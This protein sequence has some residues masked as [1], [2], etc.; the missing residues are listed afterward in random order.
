[1]ESE[2]YFELIGL[3]TGN[4]RVFLRFR[5]GTLEDITGRFNFEFR[6][7]VLGRGYRFESDLHNASLANSGR[8]ENF[9]G[10][11][12]DPDGVGRIYKSSNG[13]QIVECERPEEYSE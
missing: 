9:L 2:K 7:L 3:H 5:D 4:D 8:T 1:M 10:V 11:E 12:I 6:S 13:A